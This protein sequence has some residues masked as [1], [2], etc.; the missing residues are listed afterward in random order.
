MRS[1][2]LNS[3]VSALFSKHMREAFWGS[4]GPD[5]LFF[6]RPDVEKVAPFW[7]EL[8]R[9]QKAIS[10]LDNAVGWAANAYQSHEDWITGGLGH[11]KAVH[12]KQYVATT[13]AGLLEG[14]LKQIDVF[15]ELRPETHD[16]PVQ[17]SWRS[18]AWLDIGHHIRTVDFCR[19]LFIHAK[20]D[21][22]RLAYANGYLTHVAADVVGHG[23]V[24]ALVGGPY[25]NHW[26]RHVFVEKGMDAY[27]FRHVWGTELCSSRFY[28]KTEFP[29]ESER[30]HICQ[31]VAGALSSTYSNLGI[32][33]SVPST[34]DVEE[35]FKNL[36]GTIQSSTELSLLNFPEPEP[37]NWFEFP[38]V[39]RRR[40]EYLNNNAPPQPD[41]GFIHNPSP[42]SMFAFLVASLRLAVYLVEIAYTILTL[43]K[44]LFASINN[45]GWRFLLWLAG[46]ALYDAYRHLREYLV[47][48]G[49]LHPTKELLERHFTWVTVSDKR[50]TGN[51][52]RY[53]YDRKILDAGGYNRQTYHLFYPGKF[54]AKQEPTETT[55]FFPFTGASLDHYLYGNG[56]EDEVIAAGALLGNCSNVFSDNSSFLAGGKRF[57]VEGAILRL[58]NGRV[59]SDPKDRCGQKREAARR[60]QRTLFG[61]SDEK[62]R[63]GSWRAGL[64]RPTPSR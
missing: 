55:A 56:T 6:Y 33:T 36:H 20:S 21:Q 57:S 28:E 54:Q 52:S 22:Q 10:E 11:A 31:Q 64:P 24:N 60:V 30:G 43:D 18:W 5:F 63:F 23:L 39:L 27:A 32:Q 12:L 4:F 40:I 16:H 50:F 9:I 15:E 53:P 29:S 59:D 7:R 3:S 45:T 48:A 37:F 19:E 34:D 44:V 58:L 42:D 41:I 47:I 61:G 2:H 46:K 49:L 35:M 1:Q 8:M 17:S 38:E 26:R 25:R 51:E 13:M 62:E 14:L